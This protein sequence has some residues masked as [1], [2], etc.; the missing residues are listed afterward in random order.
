MVL[1]SKCL[2]IFFNWATTIFPS[3]RDIGQHLIVPGGIKTVDARG[4]YVLPG[5]IDTHTHFNMPFMGTNTVDDFYSGTRAALAGGTT[6]VLDFALPAKGTSLVDAFKKW[7]A[8]AD[9]VACCD[10]G[11]KVIVPEFKKGKTDIEMEALVKE[12]GVNAFKVFMAY[13]NDLMI[14]DEDLIN[15][16]D[17]AR[18]LGALTAVHAEN[19]DII[20]Y[21]V[22]KLKSLG[23]TG[24]EGHLQS[25]PEEVEAEATNR[26][27]TLAN[28]LNSPL[29]IVH[30][31]SRSAGDVIANARNRGCVVFGETI[32]AAFGTDGSHYFHKCWRHAAAHVLSPPL[33][34]DKNTPEVLIN[35]MGSGQLQT[36]GSDHCVF[37]SDQKAVGAKD[38]SKIPNGV[39][40]VEER[41]IIL[42]EKSV[43]T[44]KIDPKQ[45]VALTSTNAA[46]IFNIYPKKG[47]L[48]KGSDGDVVV[49]GPKSQTIKA[50][51]H[52]S[53]VDYNI[54]EGLQVSNGPLVVV[55]KG[56][57]V[58][59]EDGFHVVQGNGK[60]VPCP[61]NSPYVYGQIRARENQTPIEVDRSGVTKKPQTSNGDFAHPVSVTVPNDASGDLHSSI[62][63]GSPNGHKDASFY[64][65]T[66]RSGVRNL[67]DSSFNLSGAQVD[68]DK[69]GKTA[70]RVHNP[71]GGRSHGIW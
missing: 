22:K 2:T 67:Q 29:Y 47:R 68:D 45:F 60:F 33:R 46:K 26:V 64:K 50:A 51:N 14:N 6:T 42:W 19:G 66:T 63:S 59:D 61:P 62:E 57:I 25:R 55:S 1:S 21:N 56:K 24:P 5:G 52:H 37:N 32:T 40:G 70:I 17:K 30:V 18:Q 15:V 23:I 8:M 28:Q 53:N 54:F 58:L 69:K 20:D 34:S 13:K 3:F 11:L 65:G 35:L 27:I 49:W 10:Y 12:H 43:K 48:A 9:G 39:N 71:P 44:G 16:L 38:F 31:M 7:R 4:C 36:T 41:L